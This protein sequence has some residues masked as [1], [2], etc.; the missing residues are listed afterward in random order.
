MPTKKKNVSPLRVD[1]A[2]SEGE[3]ERERERERK[4]EGVPIQVVE[5]HPAEP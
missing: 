2:E 3:S 5:Q 1:A 4:K